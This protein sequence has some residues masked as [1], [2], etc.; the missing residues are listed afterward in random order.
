MVLYIMLKRFE[1]T[2]DGSIE[3]IQTKLDHRV[4]IEEFISIPGIEEQY[5]SSS[6]INHIGNSM[7]QGH[8]TTICRTNNNQYF[9]FDDSHV[10]S[11]SIEFA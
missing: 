3:G 10:N 1:R 11:R 6:V 7:D 9:E 2:E 8:Y 5:Q 4:Q